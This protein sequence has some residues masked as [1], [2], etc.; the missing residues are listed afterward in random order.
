MNDNILKFREYF[1]ENI[2][3]EI[4]SENEEKNKRVIAEFNKE[5][6]IEKIAN[7]SLSEYIYKNYDADTFCSRLAGYYNNYGRGDVENLVGPSIKSGSIN[8]KFGIYYLDGHYVNYKRKKEGNLISNPEEYFDEIKKQL[9]EVLTKISKGINNIDY[10]KYDHLKGMYNTI[11]KLAFFI[12][13]QSYLTFGNR[14]DLLKICNY[15][16]IE[17][18][19][20][21]ESPNLSYKIKKYIDDNIEET[22]GIY[23]PNICSILYDYSEKFIFAVKNKKNKDKKAIEKET[24]NNEKKH[25]IESGINEIYYGVPGCGKSFEVDSRYAKDSKYYVRTVFHP[26]YSYTD[27]VGQIMP[28]KNGKDFS[29]EPIPG[30]LTLAIVKALKNE[31]KSVSLIIEEINRGNAAA[32]FGDL[33]QLLDRKTNYRISNEFIKNY[34]DINGVKFEGVLPPNLNIIATMNTSDQN[35]FVLDNAFRRRWDFIRIKNE[36]N[37]EDKDSGL[38]EAKVVKMNI[39]WKDFYETINEYIISDDETILNNEDKRLGAYSVTAEQLKDE[40]KFADKVL[41]YL[42]D[43]IAKYNPSRWFANYEGKQIKVYDQLIEMFSNS[44][45]GLDIFSKELKDALMTKV[46]KESNSNE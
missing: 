30:P 20:N 40:K 29:Y 15:F 7:L 46:Q 6:P 10:A 43:N 1:L 19:K 16:G 28:V 44:I 8:S 25:E 38:W 35:V 45:N 22:K 31:N 14:N 32:I 18:D 34:C 42:W 37:K 13:P 27:F 24:S 4:S 9:I 11:L 12:N 17:T 3:N 33:F 2:Q 21:D 39:L 41:L 26:D 5:Y 36:L 23:G